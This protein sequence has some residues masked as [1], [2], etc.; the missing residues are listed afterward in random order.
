[1]ITSQYSYAKYG[2]VTNTIWIRSSGTYRPHGDHMPKLQAFL[3]YNFHG[4]KVV[5]M[6]CDDDELKKMKEEQKNARLEEGEKKVF[7]QG[8]DTGSISSSDE[9]ELEERAQE[10]GRSVG[11]EKEHEKRNGIL[12][13]DG[14]VKKGAGMVQ[15][16]K[17]AVMN[18]AGKQG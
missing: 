16:P 1:M 15:D 5:A 9:E 12:S 2:D 11:E 4:L 6:T 7:V 3:D 13:D 17:G 14:R 10:N 18:W 8:S